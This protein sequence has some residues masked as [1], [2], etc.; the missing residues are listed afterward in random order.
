MGDKHLEIFA[1]Y[2]LA[3]IAGLLMLLLDATHTL[4]FFLVRFVPLGSERRNVFLQD[5]GD[6]AVVGVA[7]NPFMEPVPAEITIGA[8]APWLC[9]F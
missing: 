3:V 1:C 4:T 8:I 5:F 6:V 7:D 2:S 9:A